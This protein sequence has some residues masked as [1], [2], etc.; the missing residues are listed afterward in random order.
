[1]K[2]RASFWLAG[3]FLIIS[4]ALGIIAVKTIQVDPFFHYHKPRTDQYF[5]RLNNQRSQNNGIS[6][7][8]DYTGLITGT[9]MT[10]NFRTSEAETLWGGTFIKI[11][12]S[13]GSYRELNDSI[14]AALRYNP[15]LKTVIRGLDPAKFMDDKDTMR[16]DLGQYPTYLYDEDIFNDVQYIFN[17]DVVFSRVYP[18]VRDNDASGFVPGITSFDRYSNWAKD[19]TYGRNTLFPDGI[20]YEK[21]GEPVHITAEETE[22]TRQNIEQNVVSLARSH[23]DVSFCYFFPPYSAQWWKAQVEQ[24][25]IYRHMEAARIVIEE[26]LKCPNI[27]LF[28]FSTRF[29]ITTDLNNYKDSTHY[30]EWIN[31]LM[32]QHMHDGQYRLTADNYESHLRDVLEFYRAYDFTRMNDQPDYEDDFHIASLFAVETYGTADQ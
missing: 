22:R 12:F 30:G 28:S 31:S 6:R 25:T 19:Y 23:P 7:H 3:Y 32:L 29:D 20:T 27:Q 16:S 18:M 1:M 13:G 10:E 5:Y 24:G 2:R 26:I 4:A 21:P 15:G 17:R 8:F 9:S 11:P 14:A